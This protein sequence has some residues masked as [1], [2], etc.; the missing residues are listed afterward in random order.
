VRN[1]LLTLSIGYGRDMLPGNNKKMQWSLGV[2]VR[3]SHASFI[4]INDIGLY[5]ASQ[6]ITE[7]TLHYRPRS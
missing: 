5:F 7:D 1:D 2:E 3:E 6:Y 4:L